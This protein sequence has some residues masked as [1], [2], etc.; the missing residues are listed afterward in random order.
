[1]FIL[2]NTCQEII[3]VVKKLGRFPLWNIL[4]THKRISVM[5]VHEHI[6]GVW[7]NGM[8]PQVV[9]KVVTKVPGKILWLHNL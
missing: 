5:S 1:M 9:F 3:I 2:Y 8:Y 4:K 6:S 7:R